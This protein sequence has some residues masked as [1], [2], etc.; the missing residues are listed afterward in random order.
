MIF[1]F[2]TMDVKATL[3]SANNHA[4]SL[5]VLP[6]ECVNA[7]MYPAGQ[8]EWTL[9]SSSCSG[10][11]VYL[12]SVRVSEGWLSSCKES[13][14]SSQKM[15][16][17]IASLSNLSRACSHVIS[18]GGTGGIDGM[19]VEGLR[20]WFPEH[21]YQLRERLL[22]GSYQAQPVLGVQLPKA[23][24]GYRQ[25]GI[26]T[27]VDRVV[28]QAIAQ[29]LSVMYDPLFS[30]HSYGF[31]RGRSA[32]DAI[33][34]SSGFIASGR[35]Y[36]VDMDL[37]KFFDEV[38]HRYLLQALSY[39]VGDKRVLK[40]ILK[41]L[42]AGLLQGGL[43]SQR[44][45]GTPQGGPLSPLLSNIVLDRLDKELE[46]RGHSF[47]RYADDFLIFVQSPRAA[48]RVYASMKRF[49]EEELYLKVN[50][51]KSRICRPYELNFLGYSFGAKGRPCLSAESESRLRQKIRKTTQGNRGVSLDQVIREL[52]LQLS[53]WL[54]YFRYAQMKRRLRNL[55]SWIHRRLRCY[56]LK[57]CKRALGIARLL[58]R[59]G[60]PKDRAW[61]TAGSRKD[62]WGKSATPAAHEGMSR[63]WLFEQGVLNINELYRLKHSPL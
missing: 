3:S 17:Q 54:M 55:I 29:V 44:I 48:E 53:G 18:K 13:R 9:V 39:R 52:N 40:L 5:K 8:G 62:W 43:V 30:T 50:T 51:D 11:E 19:E 14:S 12:S 23:G 16:D 46:C 35:T 45:K 36:V 47:V 2:F 58:I 37:S 22:S 63:K 60:V 15:M 42:Q 25:L 61:T 38:N 24:G 20:K 56:R 27:V 31:R 57:Q 49:L 32:H 26:P 41:F 4:D 28:Q 1:F 21:V 6:K 7:Q 33:A 34:A 59:C 10:K